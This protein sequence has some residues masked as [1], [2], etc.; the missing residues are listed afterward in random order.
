M[1]EFVFLHIPHT[2]GRLLR[3]YM[4]Y[5]GYL[6]GNGSIRCHIVHNSEQMVD[7]DLPRYFILRD[8]VE[9]IIAEYIH[10]SRRLLDIGVVNYLDL[11]NIHQDYPKFDPSNIQDYISLEET[12]NL[13]CKFLLG[14][15]DF[16]IAISDTDFELLSKGAFIYDVYQKPMNYSSLQEFLHEKID[17][18][19]VEKIYRYP[20]TLNKEERAELACHSES[21]RACNE[22]DIKL[23]ELLQKK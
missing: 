18:S 8:P 12:R 4:W 20:L 10:Y 7:N 16:G 9:R 19:I 3:K 14:R 2:S 21:I 15:K 11:A 17:V 6:T 1:R 5:K 22:Y 23:Y 13:Y